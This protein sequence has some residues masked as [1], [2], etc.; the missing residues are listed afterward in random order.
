MTD[1][2]TAVATLLGLPVVVLYCA[3]SSCRPPTAPTP[4]EAASDALY[5][6]ELQ[7]CLDKGKAA[8]SR[9]VYRSCADGVDAR[10]ADGGARP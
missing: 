6:V 3:V 8:H 5:T 4:I 2:N 10:W 7:A 1:R 9:D